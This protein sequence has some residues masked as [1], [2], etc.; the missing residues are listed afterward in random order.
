VTWQQ[1]VDG[2]LAEARFPASEVRVFKNDTLLNY[3]IA[4]ISLNNIK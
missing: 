4:F 3:Y 2:P 1:K